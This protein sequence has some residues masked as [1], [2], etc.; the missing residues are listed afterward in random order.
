MSS[1]YGQNLSV[2][3]DKRLIFVTGKGGV[4]KSTCALGLAL[5]AAKRG[6]RVLFCEF[7]ARAASSDYLKVDTIS[8]EPTQPLARDVPN[9][10]V[11]RLEP[12][13]ALKEYFAE[14]LKVKALVR[15]ATDNKVLARL[16]KITPSVDEIVLLTSIMHFEQGTHRSGLSNLDLIV[17]DMAATGHARAML[18]VPKGI[19]G[20]AKVGPLGKRCRAL[21]EMLGDRAKT[22]Y[23]IVTL[24]EELP[25]NESI[26]LANGLSGE[27]GLYTGHV[28]I[29]C[30]LPTAFEPE[31]LQLLK[32]LEGIVHE[33]VA[34]TVLGL[35]KDH[36]LEEGRQRMR[37]KQLR[38]GVKAAFTEIQYSSHRGRRLIEAIAQQMGESLESVQ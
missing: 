26:E 18:G 8:H 35:A 32:R 30:L 13:L 23:C 11:A 2:L 6:K 4:G 22:A 27:L 19:L 16:W 20:L 36:I 31:G 37:M 29:N 10:W 38:A 17:V 21:Q 24:A 7:G 33:P 3:L 1:S 5:A 34:Q 25:V 28:F 9:L 12:H 14:I 15:L